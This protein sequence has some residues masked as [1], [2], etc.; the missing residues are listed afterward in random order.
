MRMRK[1]VHV[2]VHQRWQGCLLMLH[3]YSFYFLKTIIF[4]RDDEKKKRLC[5]IKRL[6]E[7]TKI[8]QLSLLLLFFLNINMKSHM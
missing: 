1:I 8:S 6:L 3:F 2:R 5:N 7:N 4:P